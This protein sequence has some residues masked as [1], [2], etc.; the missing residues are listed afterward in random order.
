[1]AEPQLRGQ[2]RISIHVPLA[3]HD[4]DIQRRSAGRA[5]SI[6]VPLAGHDPRREYAC[7]EYQQFQSTCPLRGTTDSTQLIADSIM[8]I[9]IHVPL[10]GHDRQPVRRHERWENFNP[11]APCGARHTRQQ[12][13][14]GATTNFNPRAP[15]GARLVQSKML[16]WLGEISIHVPL[17]GHDHL[18]ANFYCLQGISIHVPLAGHDTISDIFIDLL[19]ISIHVPLAGHDDAKEVI[20]AAKADFNPRAPCGARPRQRFQHPAQD[21]FNPRA[22]CGARLLP[23]LYMIDDVEI[24]IHVPLAGHDCKKAQ[25]LLCIFVKTG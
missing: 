8:Q 18:W 16:S 1:M 23:L 11:R 25:R 6:H 21:Y 5:I 12:G 7:C 14:S 9:S 4:K 19:D 3:G 17:A 13:S 20:I 15:C 24:S 22:P 10:A 2:G